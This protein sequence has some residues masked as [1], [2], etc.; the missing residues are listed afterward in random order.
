MPLIN[1]LKI[2]EIF[3]DKNGEEGGS[4][5]DFINKII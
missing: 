4:V 2:R 5:T 3:K 1:N